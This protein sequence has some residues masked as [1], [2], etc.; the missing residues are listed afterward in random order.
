M[1]MSIQKVIICAICLFTC[2]ACF[3]STQT[4]ESSEYYSDQDDFKEV[5]AFAGITFQGSKAEQKSRYQYSYTAFKNHTL[6]VDFYKLLSAN[7][8]QNFDI[9]P[10]ILKKDHGNRYALSLMIDNEYHSIQTLAAIKG[11]QSRSDTSYLW[12]SF[13]SAKVVIFDVVESQYV[14]SINLPILECTSLVKQKPS[15]EAIQ[16]QFTH[17]LLDNNVCDTDMAGIIPAAAKLITNAPAPK[18]AN[19]MQFAVGKVNLESKAIPFIPNQFA[20]KNHAAFKR[21]LAN[22]I[23]KEISDLH[24]V[25]IQPYVADSSVLTMQGRFAGGDRVYQI[26]LPTP[27]YQIDYTLRGFIKKVQKSKNV[28][29]QADFVAFSNI[30]ILKNSAVGA[31]TI[32]DQNLKFGQRKILVESISGTDEWLYLN[33]ALH[34]LVIKSF[35]DIFD[36]KSLFID[37]YNNF[38]KKQKRQLKKQLK[39]LREGFKQCQK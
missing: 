36:F 19:L 25:A 26:N 9:S 23:T 10:R 27:Y 1:S 37:R 6:N 29:Q 30:K 35:S 22:L 5:V 13:L 28:G 18:E 24:N 8:P 39:L 20:D 14:Y 4:T 32:L 34:L 21:Y 31:K 3:A 11:S 7:S 33:E 15:N 16:A 17:M 12:Q 2:A 38:S